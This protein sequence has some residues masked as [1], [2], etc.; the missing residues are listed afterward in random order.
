MLDKTQIVLYYKNTNR[1]LVRLLMN[2]SEKIEKVRNIL[3]N[4]KKE[5]E[6][7]LSLLSEVLGELDAI[8]DF[9]EFQRSKLQ[10]IIGGKGEHSK[11]K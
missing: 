9:A 2:K 10:V 3:F 5:T 7:G 4:V 1:V 11:K 6:T 8:R